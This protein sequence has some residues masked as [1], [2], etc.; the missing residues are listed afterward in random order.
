MK[1]TARRS[2]QFGNG[3]SDPDGNAQEHGHNFTENM[4]GAVLRTF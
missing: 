1:S 2:P 3:P 4:F